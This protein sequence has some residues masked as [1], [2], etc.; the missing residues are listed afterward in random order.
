MLRLATRQGLG[1][2]V[3]TVCLAYVCALQ[4]ILA[5]LS[6]GA[7]PASGPEAL[8]FD[9]HVLCLT[10]P[11]GGSDPSGPVPAAAHR[12][13]LC[14]TLACGILAPLAP[15]A[16]AMLAYAAASAVV[17]PP[18][19]DFGARPATAPP[20]RGPGPRAPPSALV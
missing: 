6:A 20:G 7:R 2:A 4:L 18:A 11:A 16:F 1:R 5:G 8:A 9:P 13:D 14:C 15:A 10:D 12:H 17:A 19:F 3:L